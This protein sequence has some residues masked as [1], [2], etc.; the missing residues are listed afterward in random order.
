M[1][2]GEARS[3]D[4]ARFKHAKITQVGILSQ[5]RILCVYGTNYL[6]MDESIC[7]IE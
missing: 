4:V 1:Q 6:A 2:E 3:K 5:R 7:S